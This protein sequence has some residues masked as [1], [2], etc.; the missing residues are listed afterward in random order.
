MTSEQRR[1][2]ATLWLSAALFVSTLAVYWR[3]RSFG[4][5]SYDDN[6]YVYENEFVRRGLTW[7]GVRWAFSGAHAGNWHPL[8]WISHMLDVSLFGLKPSGHHLISLLLH[9]ANAVLLFLVLK[10]MT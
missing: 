9:I 4:F 7:D 8:T 6:E 2:P 3:V 1:A 5:V 10:R